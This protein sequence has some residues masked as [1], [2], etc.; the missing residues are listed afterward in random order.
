MFSP[1]LQYSC[2]CWASAKQQLDDTNY[3]YAYQAADWAQH[4]ETCI[5][6]Y[7]HRSRST[8]FTQTEEARTADSNLTSETGPAVECIKMSP[9]VNSEHL[10]WE[11]IYLPLSHAIFDTNR[12]P[13][14]LSARLGFRLVVYWLPKNPNQEVK[15]CT[16]IL[17]LTMS[18][19]T[20]VPTLPPQQ[21]GPGSFYPARKDRWTLPL[22]TM[23]VILDRC[24]TISKA[25]KRGDEPETVMNL[26]EY[27]VLGERIRFF[28]DLVNHLKK[29]PREVMVNMHELRSATILWKALENRKWEKSLSP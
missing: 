1:M 8:T 7:I 2:C 20:G 22:E 3:R 14:P 12:E 23:W 10:S 26:Y 27:E 17:L 16:W 9:T 18:P 11:P 15:F 19:T 4:K 28:T 13:L 5:S 6:P 24:L 29:P 25:F 21:K